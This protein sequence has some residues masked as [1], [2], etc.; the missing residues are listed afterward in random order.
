MDFD[1]RKFPMMYFS[2]IT[3]HVHFEYNIFLIIIL[4][5]LSALYKN[6]LKML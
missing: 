5:P 4:Y 6:I 3:I 2:N 1:E